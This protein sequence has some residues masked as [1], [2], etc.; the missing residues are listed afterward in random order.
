MIA[1]RS[2]AVTGIWPSL[3]GRSLGEREVTG[4]NPVIPTGEWRS[5]AARLL[6]EQEAVGSNPAFPTRPSGRRSAGARVSC[7]RAVSGVRCAPVISCLAARPYGTVAV[8]RIDPGE[9]STPSSLPRSCSS[10]GTS[11]RLKP[12]RPQVRLLA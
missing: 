1:T 5:L 2:G 9:G 12:G 4:S 3:A 6:R 7:S 11:V 8:G 10:V